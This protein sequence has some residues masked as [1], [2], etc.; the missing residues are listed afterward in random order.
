MVGDIK[1]YLKRLFAIF[2]KPKK[3]CTV[4]FFKVGIVFVLLFVGVSFGFEIL[5]QTYH[6]EFA[7][8]PKSE[9]IFLRFLTVNNKTIDEGKVGY[10]QSLLEVK[11]VH[12]VTSAFVHLFMH[13]VNNKFF[14]EHFYAALGLGFECNLF[15]IAHITLL[16]LYHESAHL[17]DGFPLNIET[18][19]KIISNESIQFRLE[20]AYRNITTLLQ[21]DYYW[22]SIER[23]LKYNIGAGLEW[24]SKSF[25]DMQ[26]FISGYGFMISDNK[27]LS[28]N[29]TFL[30]GLFI[31]K[32]M[33]I[34]LYYENQMG[35]G[36]DY[37]HRQKGYG[38]E[39]GFR[40]LFENE[41]S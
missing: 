20:G 4:P 19:K 27:G 34:G 30:T 13:P 10:K 29:S 8:N 33:H 40:R 32:K 35:L 5:P 41:N 37:N 36:Q 31:K 2:Y 11:E 23:Q 24:K 39:L 1:M 3:T 12:I 6:S 26:F 16:P 21:A 15:N 9:Q 22:H 14:V 38:L 25:S 28:F 18:N 17:A 7:L